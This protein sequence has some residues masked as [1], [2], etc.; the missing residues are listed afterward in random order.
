MN[1]L[2]PLILILLLFVSCS[3]QPDGEHIVQV[4][5][6]SPMI[7]VDLN[8]SILN[9]TIYLRS[10]IN[11]EFEFKSSHGPIKSS[12]L[13]VGNQTARSNYNV[14]RSIVTFNNINSYNVG[15]LDYNLSITYESLPQVLEDFYTDSDTTLTFS[16]VMLFESIENHNFNL[17]SFYRENGKSFIEING[18]RVFDQIDYLKIKRRNDAGNESEFIV[19]DVKEKNLVEI[20]LDIGDKCYYTLYR[21]YKN[22]DYSYKSPVT[23]QVDK[24][25]YDLR[26]ET[27]DD[28]NAKIIFN[29]IPFYENIELIKIDCEFL[30]DG[31]IEVPVTDTS[32]NVRNY[33]FA[34]ETNV[35]ITPISKY[36]IEDFDRYSR[37][38]SEETEV[39][40]GQKT[41][42]P[43]FVT[44][45]KNIKDGLAYRWNNHLN[46]LNTKTLEI[47]SSIDI[48]S[49]SSWWNVSYSG[50]Y[51]AIY[52]EEVLYVSGRDGHQR[53]IN[54]KPIFGVI[55]QVPVLTI[56]DNGIIAIRINTQ[57]QFALI[58][59]IT[60]QLIWKNKDEI[61]Y[62]LTI[63]PN[64]NYLVDHFIGSG[65][66]NVYKI[67]GSEL[68]LIYEKP[69]S[70][71][72]FRGFINNETIIFESPGNIRTYNLESKDEELN[73]VTNGYLQSFDPSGKYLILRNVPNSNYSLL[74]NYEINKFVDSIPQW[75]YVNNGKIFKNAFFKEIKNWNI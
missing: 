1:H 36:E 14:D 15:Y 7:T 24:F 39:I 53:T 65:S 48:Q 56:S 59:G 9:D 30:P 50:N 63:S 10:K 74:F 25:D 64:G 8:Q 71:F 19:Y 2:K 57:K 6:I 5:E 52:D 4:D 58:N 17:D 16:G 62:N 45:F 27:I 67:N 54:L 41:G 3:Y 44:S 26:I 32:V 28:N 75:S 18:N 42:I 20:P 34:T 70:S 21:H 31:S 66:F 47:D 46:I 23:L 69:V 43:E 33:I 11:V 51:C 40:F 22:H 49:Y 13:K 55:T 68:E 37:Y 61:R 72:Q 35:I 60:G 38:Y 29:K 12:V 73:I